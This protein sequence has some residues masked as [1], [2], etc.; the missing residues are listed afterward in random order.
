MPRLPHGAQHWEFQ[1]H[2][3]Y[4]DSLGYNNGPRSSPVINDGLVYLFGAEG[5]L[6]CVRASDGAGLEGRYCQEVPRGARTSSALAARRWSKAT[7]S[8]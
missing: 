2:T 5:M 8:W 7:C 1:Y 6:H 4:S 3:D